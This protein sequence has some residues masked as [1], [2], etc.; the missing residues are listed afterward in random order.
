MLDEYNE[1][2]AQ[3]YIQD[4]II[5]LAPFDTKGNKVNI[6]FSKLLTHSCGKTIAIETD[7]EDTLA[8]ARQAIKEF[9]E[10]YEPYYPHRT[11]LT[12]DVVACDIDGV[13]GDDVVACDGCLITSCAI[14]RTY[15]PQRHLQTIAFPKLTLKERWH[16]ALGF[17][18]VPSLNTIHLIC[19]CPYL[20]RYKLGV[21]EYARKE[22]AK[23]IAA[24]PGIIDKLVNFKPN[25][26][27]EVFF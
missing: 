25:M 13:A 27:A 10:I 6:P 15:A 14:V 1:A 11:L 23:E 7:N 19:W 17:Y 18:M 12:N 5:A 20:V 4:D 3:R 26:K 24:I 22:L 2:K 16:A 9:N 21:H 8:L